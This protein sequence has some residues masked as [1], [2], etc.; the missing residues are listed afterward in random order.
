M[1]L[2][3]AYAASAETIAARYG[4]L[5]RA[6]GANGSPSYRIPCPA[7]SGKSRNLAIWDGDD[8]S[9]GA[10]CWS[11][12]CAYQ[13]ILDALGVEYT[14]E[15]RRYERGDGTS[16]RRRRGPGKDLTRNP[17]SPDGVMVKLGSSDR[18]ENAVVLC[19]GPK[20]ADAFEC[21]GFDDYT[22]AHWDGGAGG[23]DKFDSSP[24]EGRHV[25]LWPD[26]GQRGLELME[27]AAAHIQSVAETARLVDVS[28][29]TN[30]QDAADVD[31][32]LAERM[33]RN[34]APYQFRGELL[35]RLMQK[36][37][38]PNRVGFADLLLEEHVE[39]LLC[40]S[41]RTPKGDVEADPYYLRDTGLWEKNSPVLRSHVHDMCQ[42]LKADTWVLPPKG[43]IS[44]ETKRPGA[45][46]KIDAAANSADAV[47]ALIPDR[48]KSWERNRPDDYEQVEDV[49]EQDLD[50][51]CRYLGCA[52]G[53]VDL[54]AGE[55]LPPGVARR[56]LVTRSTGVKYV[57][58]ATHPAV[59]KLTEH[60]ADDLEE[61][62]WACLGR[63]LWGRPEKFFTLIVGPGDSG[64]STL[65]SAIGAAIGSWGG[66]F[67]QDMLRSARSDKGK[68][69]PTPEREPLTRCR[70]IWALEAEAF[71]ID[72]VKMKNFAGGEQDS[73]VH[74]PKF[75]AEGTYPLRAT[76]FI[77]GNNYPALALDDPQ[78]AERLRCIPYP[79]PEKVDPSLARDVR[80]PAAAEATLSRLVAAATAN[81]PGREVPVPETVRR[82]IGHRV[83]LARGPFGD[84]LEASLSRD[85][86]HRVSAG[87][88]W[89]A[90][91]RYCSTSPGVGEAGG[92]KRSDLAKRIRNVFGIDP[93]Q[94]RVNG[95]K[96]RGYRDMRLNQASADPTLTVCAI[97]GCNEPAGGPLLGKNDEPLRNDG[98]VLLLCFH[99]ALLVTTCWV[100]DCVFVCATPESPPLCSD[101]AG[102]AW[103]LNDLAD[104]HGHTSPCGEPGCPICKRMERIAGTVVASGQQTLLGGENAT[105]GHSGTCDELPARGKST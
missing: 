71:P 78:L 104:G 79:K 25:I 82:E 64:K 24:L 74:Q 2:A 6:S 61:Y 94:L 11:K 53:V 44:D 55:L 59:D 84:W 7:H 30:G 60:L 88:V 18:P 70:L 102:E 62:L 54:Q 57:P 50:R 32:E 5:K 10:K 92:L 96:T 40:A 68:Q 8:G 75:R 37:H 43:L 19:E 80:T 46:A 65:F 90:W 16:V 21:F 99:H 72:A 17:G 23:A 20:A 51:D 48:A 26:A 58:G 98:E 52:N 39:R 86:G 28:T 15:G 34:A 31:R 91:A 3:P 81:Q 87:Q 67:G 36:E 47:A 85:P 63:A 69:G 105:N 73:I 101:H 38:Y 29:L 103:R 35:R 4:P 14:Y 27:K 49:G 45:K 83:S 100:C 56:H 33:L 22:A 12:G 97:L 9:L 66:M 76:I 1:V 93:K 13:D 95:E 41:Y 89:E 42:R 77:T